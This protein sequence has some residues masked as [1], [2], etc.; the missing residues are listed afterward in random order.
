MLAIAGVVLA[1]VEAVFSAAGAASA[2]A[3]NAKDAKK[4]YFLIDSIY[5]TIS[6]D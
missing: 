6:P 5:L 1:A 2:W 3:A 4:K